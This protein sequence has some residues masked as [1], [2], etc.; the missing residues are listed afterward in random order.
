MTSFTDA[1][2]MYEEKLATMKIQDQI[3]FEMKNAMKNGNPKLRD[4]MRVVMGEFTR[5]GKELTD[6][7][8]LA[9]IKKMHKDATLMKNDYEMAVLD[10]WIPKTLDEEKTKALLQG[11]I[12]GGRFTGLQ[13][14]GKLMQVLKKVNNVDMKLASKLAKEL[15][16]NEQEKSKSN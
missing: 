2:R 5:E 1:L 14:M 11:M 10:R 6:E 3:A 7:Q 9:V 16:E 15:L 13:D 4:L 8:S 12:W